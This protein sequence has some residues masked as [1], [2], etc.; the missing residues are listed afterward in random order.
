[1]CTDVSLSNRWITLA[2]SPWL[3]TIIISKLNFEK[4]D[5]YH[6]LIIYIIIQFQCKCY[7]ILTHIKY[8][9]I[10]VFEGMFQFEK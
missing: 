9:L 3:P 6:L 4:P 5:S 2:T 7:Y 8:F 10:L 1:M